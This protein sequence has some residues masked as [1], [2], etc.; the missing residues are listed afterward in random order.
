MRIQHFILSLFSLLYIGAQAQTFSSKDPDYIKYVQLGEKALLAEKYDSCLIYYDK[1]FDIKQTS[2]LSTMRAATCAYGAKNELVLDQ[3][4]D[5]AY[6]INYSQAKG[7]FEAYPE[8]EPY[9]NSALHERIQNDWNRL[10]LADGLD[11]ELIE[12]MKEVRISDQA[13]RQ[14]M[15]A[16]SE[17]Y[18]WQSPQMDSLWVLQSYSDSVNTVF[19]SNL[20]DERG[21]PGKSMVGSDLAS[22]AFLVIQHADIEVQ[23]KYLN[24]IK[25]AADAEEVRWSSVALLIDRINLRTGKAQIYGSQVSRDEETGEHYFSEIEN[26]DKVDSLR[27]TVGLGPLQSYADNWEFT[28]DPEKHKERIAKMKAAAEKKD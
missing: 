27:A 12:K 16:V 28:W 17:K 5:T 22:T 3:M 21:Y 20:I 25:A 24:I 6:R 9:L 18:G 2:V 23:Q 1:A 26:P 13:Q 19:I 15:R 4:L 14:E 10:A 11:L 7:L 8:F